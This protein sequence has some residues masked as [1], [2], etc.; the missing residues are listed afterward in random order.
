MICMI[1]SWF[2]SATNVSMGMPSQY[3][4]SLQSVLFPPS[5][6]LFSPI[7][8]NHPPPSILCPQFSGN[9]PPSS[10]LRPLSSSLRPLLSSLRP[11]SSSLPQTSSTIHLPF[12]Q[13]PS[14]ILR[15][16]GVFTV[17]GLGR[18][19]FYIVDISTTPRHQS[20]IK[21][22]SWHRPSINCGLGA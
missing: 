8:I 1:F 17:Q 7:S 20:C 16:L 14:S 10:I 21:I 6:L 13:P 15:P 2:G 11:P 22:N 9:H 12:I 18:S 3:P 5:S 4:N 19:I